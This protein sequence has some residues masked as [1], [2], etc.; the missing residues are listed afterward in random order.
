M[1]IHTFDIFSLQIFRSPQPVSKKLL[2]EKQASEQ[3]GS[4]LILGWIPKPHDRTPLATNN[5]DK[6]WWLK[7]VIGR[8]RSFAV[9]YE[10]HHLPS[11]MQCE[12]TDDLSR[13]NESDAV[14]FRGWRL[15]K[16]LIPSHR[17]PDQRWIFVEHESPYR[18]AR[19]INL[20]KYDGF[21]NLTA[22]YSIDSDIPNLEY[23]QHCVRDPTKLKSLHAKEYT[24]KKRSDVLVA[25]LVSD[26]G[27]QSEREYYVIELQKYMSIDIYGKCGDLECGK[28]S[29]WSSDNCFKKLLNDNGS[30]K[31]Y[32]SFENSLCDD[33]VTEKFW[34][35]L[36]LDVVPIVRGAVDYT[37]F[38]PSDSYIDV[39][40]FQGPK[41]LAQYLQY[42]NQHDDLYNQYIRNKNSLDCTYAMKMPWECLLCQ[43]LHNQKGERKVIHSLDNFWGVKRCTPPNYFNNQS[44]VVKD[45]APDLIEQ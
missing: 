5:Y 15:D 8:S 29:T 13:Y 41:E 26:C 38:I 18:V 30:Y 23:V 12:Y 42:L 9:C 10:R 39:R 34:S 45:V 2:T 21:F 37:K 14:L 44:S 27:T 31:F 1:L 3:N 24:E 32:L 28:W 16:S 40:D 33:Y 19:K 6:D 20:N 11:K 36:P 4:I 17:F 7:L 25:W 35:I 22:T 43:T